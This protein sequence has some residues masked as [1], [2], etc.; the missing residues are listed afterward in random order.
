MPWPR[1]RNSFVNDPEKTVISGRT[2]AIGSKTGLG[3][4][5]TRVTAVPPPSPIPDVMLE[6]ELGRGG[7]GV[8]YR[9]RQVYLDR[10][11]AVKLLLV[12]GAEGEEFVRRFQREAKILASLAHPNIVA[13]YQA[14][15]TAANNP[16]LV[17]EFID[18]PTLKGWIEQHGRVPV[19]QAV[20]ITRDLARALDHAHEQGIIHRDV[21]PENVLLA[22]QS[23]PVVGAFPFTAKLVD[24]GLAR[25]SA[26]VG[27]MNLTRQGVVMGTPSTMA[28]EQFDDP[29]NVDYRADIYG[30]GC[31][32]YHALVGKPAFDGNTL[33]A[34]VTAKVSGT[35]PQPTRAKADV[36]VAVN[37]LVGAMLARDRDKRPQSYREIIDRCDQLL[38]DDARPLGRQGNRAAWIGVL[39]AVVILGGAALAALLLRTPEVPAPAPVAAVKP[40]PTQATAPAMPVLV[41]LP[42][43]AIRES[44]WGQAQPLW[45][46]DV[47]QRLKQWTAGNGAL[48]NSAETRDDAV[49]GVA[50]RIMRPLDHMPCRIQGALQHSN[51]PDA[52]SDDG[53]VG[54][55][56]AD[57]GRVDLSIVNLGSIVQVGVYSYKPN[58]ELPFN[59][60]GPVTLPVSKAVPFTLILREDGFLASVDG[61]AFMALA[62]ASP[63]V[64]LYL[65]SNQD[66]KTKAPVEVSGLVIRRLK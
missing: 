13:C 50:G 56:L 16:Y 65:G 40:A 53:H 4:D 58:E 5:S 38:G 44:D 22:K 23:A 26:G 20:A 11:V 55:V 28:P 17:M 25:P 39:A 33:A 3:E 10:A 57:G 34:I 27:D 2:E 6:K 30:L 42:L 52:K 60:Q 37:E 8:V 62:L 51:D 59:S 19:A 66:G 49:A 47:T 61:N 14:G 31:V 45:Q 54:V 64:Q 63:P 15:V 46:F 9:G 21:K 48:W 7:M 29:D 18:G 41:K 36:P 35:I 32:L 12:H 1:S 43:D 24:L